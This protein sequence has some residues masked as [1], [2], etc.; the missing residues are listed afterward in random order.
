MRGSRESPVDVT[1]LELDV[2]EVVAAVLLVEERRV[3][4]ER[5]LRIDDR[6]ERLVLDLDELAAVLGDV[7]GRG[8]HGGDGLAD[9]ANAVDWQQRAV[10]FPRLR[11]RRAGD[12]LG[13][14]L[15]VAGRDDGGDPVERPRL[16]RAN[17]KDVR[18]RVR[19]ADERN[20]EHPRQAHVVEESC[21]AAEELRVLHAWQALTDVAERPAHRPTFFGL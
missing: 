1:R 8:D 15:E 9:V 5:P 20:V 19:A 6:V 21:A 2:R 16:R 7:A 4:L 17:T 12:D 18:V 13:H 11:P 3:R 14:S 10:P